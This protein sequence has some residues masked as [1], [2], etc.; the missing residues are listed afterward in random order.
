MIYGLKKQNIIKKKTMN[1]DY[2]N[3]TFKKIIKNYK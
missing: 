2:E 1:F 3:K